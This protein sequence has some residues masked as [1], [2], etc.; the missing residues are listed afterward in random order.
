MKIRV[1]F[2]SNS[3]TTSFT[4]VLREDATGNAVFDL[5]RKI[6][7][8]GNGGIKFH[9]TTVEY[10]RGELQNTL[11]DLKQN[12]ECEQKCLALLKPA[13]KHK[14]VCKL[15]GEVFDA[16]VDYKKYS[17]DSGLRYHSY[18]NPVR[19]AIKVL[20]SQIQDIM[21][22]QIK[23]QEQ[24]KRLSEFRKDQP[25]I[26]WEEDIMSGMFPHVVEELVAQDK[27]VVLESW[28]S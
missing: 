22:R 13:L 25:V 8:K 5:F 11:S 15:V 26:D 4:V 12:L 16:L 28:R 2:V 3:S 1:G 24:L 10:K 19:G 20:K 6:M 18:S 14:G 9:E 27:I 7:S 21:E 17:G 23:V